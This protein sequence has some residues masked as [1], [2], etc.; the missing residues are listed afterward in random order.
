MLQHHRQHNGYGR[1]WKGP[2]LTATVSTVSRSASFSI[3]QEETLGRLTH[4]HAVYFSLLPSISKLFIDNMKSVLNQK[5]SVF[6]LSLLYD[7]RFI[8]KSAQNTSGLHRF[9]TCSKFSGMSIMIPQ[10][11]WR[12]EGRVHMKR[13]P[14]WPFTNFRQLPTFHLSRIY[15]WC[16]AMRF[17]RH[18]TIPVRKLQSGNHWSTINS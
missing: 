4:R 15:S 8:L 17:W 5:T 14:T 13:N 10:Q 6:S 1:C 2:P 18:K 3:K 16:S 11:M 12:R 9:W 7:G